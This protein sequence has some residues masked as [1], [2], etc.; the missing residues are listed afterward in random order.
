MMIHFS[1]IGNTQYIHK[2]H[3]CNN[4][5][6]LYYIEIKN[7]KRWCW[8]TG[9][10]FEN[11][12]PTVVKKQKVEGSCLFLT[13]AM[14]LMVQYCCETE[15]GA[16]HPAFTQTALTERTESFVPKTKPNLCQTNELKRPTWE[17]NT[18]EESLGKRPGGFIRS[19]VFESRFIL[20]LLGCSK[21]SVGASWWWERR[22]QGDGSSSPSSSEN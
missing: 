22:A 8:L 6:N 19:C 3:Q 16:L 10:S 12:L 13:P 14:Y 9:W 5:V 15:G 21:P 4:S 11:K 20:H 7:K 2:C 17:V 1:S 18:N